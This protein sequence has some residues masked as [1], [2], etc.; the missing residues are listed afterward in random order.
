MITETLMYG[1]TCNGCGADYESH[2]G[3]GAMSGKYSMWEYAQE[4]NWNEIEGEPDKHYC[5][6][7]STADDEGNVTLKGKALISEL[8]NPTTNE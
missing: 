1:V 3:Y 7:C 8:N 4:D 2:H 6:D 5:P